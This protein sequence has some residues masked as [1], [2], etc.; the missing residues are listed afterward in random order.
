MAIL[1]EGNDNDKQ[2]VF[3][4]YEIFSDT[5]ITFGI[6]RFQHEQLNQYASEKQLGTEIN[7]TVFDLS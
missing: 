6:W 3:L 7:I 4:G 2:F 5:P 1:R